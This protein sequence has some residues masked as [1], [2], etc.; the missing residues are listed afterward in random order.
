MGAMCCGRD[1]SQ[2]I[3]LR[4]CLFSFF[5]LEK[6]KHQISGKNAI[7]QHGI[8]RSPNQLLGIGIVF[9]A[10]NIAVSALR[11]LERVD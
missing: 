2:I 10:A 5:D 3:Y 4:N 6:D 1:I 9:S 11:I 8:Q 7:T